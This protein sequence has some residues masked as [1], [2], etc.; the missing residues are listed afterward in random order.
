MGKGEMCH[1]KDE[2]EIICKKKIFY[3]QMREYANGIVICTSNPLWSEV[4]SFW[5][6]TCIVLKYNIFATGIIT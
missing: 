5:D 1:V 3:I 2:V 4:S 6:Q